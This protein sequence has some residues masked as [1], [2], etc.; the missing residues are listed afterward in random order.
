[1]D[2]SLSQKFGFQVRLPSDRAGNPASE[3]WIFSMSKAS[4]NDQK[5][6]MVKQLDTESLTDYVKLRTFLKMG[7]GRTL[8]KAFKQ[9]YETTHE[10]SQ[11]W[12][13]L[14]EKHQWVRRTAEY[15][16]VDL[17]AGA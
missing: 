9:Y 4:Q 14:A 11:V 7:P 13:D 6:G 16:Q 5:H 15:D 12:I 1:M 10:V 3:W 17:S 8:D 2:S